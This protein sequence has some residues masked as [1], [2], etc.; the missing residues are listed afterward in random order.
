MFRE[1]VSAECPARV[2]GFFLASFAPADLSLPQSCSKQS[3]GTDPRA[4]R[5]D[6]WVQSVRC[7][8]LGQVCRLT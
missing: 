5:W 7:V 4:T 8:H 3:R 1:A 6:A 2:F